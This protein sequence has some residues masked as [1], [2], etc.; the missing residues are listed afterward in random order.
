MAGYVSNVAARTHKIR[1]LLTIS[2]VHCPGD[3]DNGSMEK[4][5]A[6]MTYYGD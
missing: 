5:G 3:V 6:I 1:T 2:G 4:N